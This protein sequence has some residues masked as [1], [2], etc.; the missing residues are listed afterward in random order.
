VDP[1]TGTLFAGLPAVPPPAEVFDTLCQARGVRIE[2]I[3][4]WGHATAA[5]EWYDQAADEWVVLLT[6]AAHLLVDGRADVLHL[7]PGDWVFLPA[8]LRHRVEWTDPAGPTV[9]LAVHVDR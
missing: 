8:R 9:W 7:R 3:V 4:S 2:R 6:G 1:T 5:G